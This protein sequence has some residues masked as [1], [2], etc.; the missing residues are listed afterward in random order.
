MGSRI[1]NSP[2]Y[3]KSTGSSIIVRIKVK[4]VFGFQRGYSKAE[5]GVPFDSHILID[6]VTIKIIELSPSRALL[7]N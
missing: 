5:K 6:K 3:T 1:K 7:P 2:L 4:D